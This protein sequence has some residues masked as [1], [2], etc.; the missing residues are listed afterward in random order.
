MGFDGSVW[1]N[2]GR[3]GSDCLI[4]AVRFSV[5]SSLKFKSISVSSFRV[6]LCR[7]GNFLKGLQPFFVSRGLSSVVLSDRN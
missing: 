5:I 7:N 3:I 2:S 4:K 6:G 1:W